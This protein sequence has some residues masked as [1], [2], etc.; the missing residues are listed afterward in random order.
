MRK[1]LKRLLGKLQVNHSWLFVGAETL[2][3][4][5][6]FLAIP[7][8]ITGF[9]PGHFPVDGLD[10]WFPAVLWVI[11]GVFV[12]INNLYD[13]VPDFNRQAAF[14]LLALWGFYFGMMC[15][16]DLNDPRPPVIGLATIFYGVIMLRILV[17]LL[18][19]DPHKQTRGGGHH[20]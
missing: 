2:I 15:A 5:V 10:N 20:G 18:F 14:G 19:D 17:L 4:G 6:Y 16:R 8:S 11:L 1:E 13:V 3:V 7:G 9:V 12:I